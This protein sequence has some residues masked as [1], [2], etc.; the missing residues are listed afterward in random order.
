MNWIPNGHI[1]FYNTVLKTTNIF[2][3]KESLG[4]LVCPR[5][6]KKKPAICVHVHDT[7]I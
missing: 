1:K 3:N 2:T 7:V 5:I 4:F 6:G